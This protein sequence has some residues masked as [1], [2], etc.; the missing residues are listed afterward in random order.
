M[1]NTD[2]FWVFFFTELTGTDDFMKVI[3]G[4]FWAIFGLLFSFIDLKTKK[5]RRPFVE[6]VSILEFIKYSMAVMICM[7]FFMFIFNT[8]NISFAGFLIGISIR[9]LPKIILNLRN[10]YLNSNSS[11]NGY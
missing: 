6:H 7:R 3:F 10:N 8:D 9:N 1:I 2:N 11:T 4:Y 5:A